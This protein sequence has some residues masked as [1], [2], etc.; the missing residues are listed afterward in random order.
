MGKTTC[1]L[2]VLLLGLA[3]LGQ[4]YALRW[5]PVGNEEGVPTNCIAEWRDIGSRTNLP[6]GFSFVTNGSGLRFYL[7]YSGTNF[8][9]WESNRVFLISSNR[10]FWTG[11][12][13]IA[14]SNILRFSTNISAQNSTI[15]STNLIMFIGA[16]ER[17]RQ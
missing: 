13:D 5:H 15:M 8:S 16:E 7:A 4:N 10:T 14:L 17:L 6:S 1:T 12:R 3:A 11:R 9:A 2:I